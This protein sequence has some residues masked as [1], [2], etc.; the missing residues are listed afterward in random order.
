[1][2]T[3]AASKIWLKLAGVSSIPNVADIETTTL[4][5]EESLGS[6]V[7]GDFIQPFYAH[8]SKVMSGIDGTPAA[9]MW[10]LVAMHCNLFKPARRVTAP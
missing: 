3:M 5:F 10:Y 1:M 4:H 8:S 2:H 6:V 7:A 9:A